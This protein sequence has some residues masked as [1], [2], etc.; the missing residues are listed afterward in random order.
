MKKLI[1]LIL[2]VGLAGALGLLVGKQS[3]DGTQPASGLPLGGDFNLQTHEGPLTLDALRGRVVLLYFGYAGCPDVCPTS[4]A[5]LGSAMKKLTPAELE[6]VQGLFISVDPE[7]DTP[8]RLAQYAAFFHPQMIGAT[9]DLAAINDLTRRYGAAYMKV[10]SGEE[11]DYAVD[12][13]SS[14][15]V[16]GPDGRLRA[17]LPHGTPAEMIATAAREQLAK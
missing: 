4:L 12:H 9:S 10:P 3:I 16:I 15:Y 1:P 17:I 14:T 13:T 6:R 11:G 5:V 8:E 2:I 7:R